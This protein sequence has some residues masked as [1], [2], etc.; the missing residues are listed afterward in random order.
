MCYLRKDYLFQRHLCKNK[1]EL[2]QEENI[3]KMSVLEAYLGPFPL[4]MMDLF[5][6]IVKDFGRII[7][8]EEHFHRIRCLTG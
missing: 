2:M 4:S 8:L 3:E 6:K 1:A 5:A 7:F